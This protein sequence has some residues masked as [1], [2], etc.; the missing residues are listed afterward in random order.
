MKRKRITDKQRLD[1]C[2]RSEYNLPYQLVDGGWWWS[3]KAD[4][5]G[6]FRQAIDAAIRAREGEK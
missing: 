5:K 1:W 3:Y 6:T 2:E 4:P